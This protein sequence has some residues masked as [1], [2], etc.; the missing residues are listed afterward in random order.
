MAIENDLAPQGG[1]QTST[2]VTPAVP[3]EPTPHETARQTVRRA[4]EEAKAR[5]AERDEGRRTS[6]EK[7][8]S[9]P[10]AP[11]EGEDPGKPSLDRTRQR[12]AQGRFVEDPELHAQ[13]RAEYKRIRGEG[14]EPAPGEKPAGRLLKSRK[15]KNRGP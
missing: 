11:A 4:F 8:G 13:V 2:P 12:D 3:A 5:A 14:Q 9:E 15:R 10:R 7:T 6:G 1:E